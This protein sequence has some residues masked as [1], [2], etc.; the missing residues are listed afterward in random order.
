MPEYPAITLWQPWATLVAAGLKPY[1]FRHWPAPRALWG[2]RVAIHAGARPMRRVELQGLLR[3]IEKDSG[4]GT[5]LRP[6]AAELVDRA[7]TA[8]RSLPL[9]SV[10]C[11]ATLHEPRRP[12][13]LFGRDVADSDRIDKH[14]WAWPLTDI[15]RLEPYVPATGRQGWWMWHQQEE[16][17]AA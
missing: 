13:V 6:G 10:L 16:D 4:W 14:V 8:P 1:E 3:S 15:T 2:R 9:A 17:R 12:V 11:L 7:L 5:A